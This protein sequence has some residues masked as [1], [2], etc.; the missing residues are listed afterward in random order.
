MYRVWSIHIEANS[1][2]SRKVGDFV[3]GWMD[4]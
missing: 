2:V 3:Q 4:S 1:N